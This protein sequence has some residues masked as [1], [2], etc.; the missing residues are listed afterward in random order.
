[1]IRGESEHLANRHPNIRRVKNYRARIKVVQTLEK[2]KRETGGTRPKKHANLGIN[3]ERRLRYH[4]S[5][6]LVAVKWVRGD[7]AASKKKKAGF[8][9]QEI[10]DDGT[11]G[12]TEGRPR[13]LRGRSHT[14]KPGV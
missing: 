6:E 11:E 1:M 14:K 12:R 8:C 3:L 9:Q 4:V 2:K 10:V 5:Q 7:L 13:C